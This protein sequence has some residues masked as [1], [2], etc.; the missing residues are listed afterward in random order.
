VSAG[1]FKEF[2]GNA[3]FILPGEAEAKSHPLRIIINRRLRS[4]EEKSEEPE[5]KKEFETRIIIQSGYPDRHSVALVVS[6]NIPKVIQFLNQQKGESP[7]NA[8]RRIF[9][10]ELL[11]QDIFDEVRKIELRY[12]QN[13]LPSDGAYHSFAGFL[14]SALDKSLTINP[15]QVVQPTKPLAPL[16]TPAAPVAAVAPAAATHSPAQQ[17]AASTEDIEIPP[18]GKTSLRGPITNGNFLQIVRAALNNKKHTLTNGQIF[19]GSKV[20]DAPDMRA[21][22]MLIKPAP[23][24]RSQAIMGYMSIEAAD[25]KEAALIIDKL[26]SLAKPG[27][28]GVTGIDAVVA[29]REN[30]I[31]K[32]MGI[33]TAAYDAVLGDPA[34]KD[35][36]IQCLNSGGRINLADGGC[37][38]STSPPARPGTQLSSP[39]PRR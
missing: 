15:E 27:A 23:D 25:D 14:K 11:H 26:E 5:N 10:D 24:Q 22:Y 7:E 18:I 29:E 13:V 9:R 17:P 34:I 19:D 8:R 32:K 31:L 6:D 30:R 37:I 39:A 16:P 38:T 12:S 20:H 35:T 4:A 28:V 2:S 3:L 1:S 33:N 21:I 36:M